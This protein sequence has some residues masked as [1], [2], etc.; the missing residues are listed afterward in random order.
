MKK[1]VLILMMAGVLVSCSQDDPWSD[2]ENISGSQENSMNGGFVEGGSGKGATLTNELGTFD[3]KLDA[4]PLVESE[5]IPDESD[6]YYEDYVECFTPKS[7]IGVVF[8]E[9]TATVNGSA[10][11][12]TI[13][14]DGAHVTVN[15]TVKNVAYILS[16]ST[17]NGSF[18]IYSEKKF[19]LTLNGVS[20]TNPNGAAINNQGKRAYVVVNDGTE[21]MLADGSSYTMVE[22][23]DQKGTL[24]SEGKLAFSGKG[25]LAVYANG[26]SGIVSDDYVL[27]RPN[28]NIYVKSVSNHGIKSNDGIIIKGGVVNVEVS[29]A[30]SKGLNTDGFIQIDGGRTSVITTGETEYDDE[31]KE[32]KGCAA[33][34]ADSII[35]MNGGKLNVKSIGGGGKGISSD[36]TF[37]MNGGS[38][39]AIAQGSNSNDVSAKAIKI[40]GDIVIAGG[41][42]MARA[43]SHEAIESKGKMTITAGTVAAYSSDDAINSA[44][45]MHI[46]GGY[47]YAYSTGNDAIDANGNLTISGGVVIA[48][49]A[50]S[51]EE[52]IDAAEGKTLSF[53]G[54]TII[55]IGG[56][57]E[58]TSGSQ[59]KATIRGISISSG[60]YLTVHDSN[61]NNIFAFKT[62]RAYSNA[63]LQVSSP[64]FSSG[65]TYTLGTASS[66]SGNDSFYGFISSATVSG[67]T[68][69]GTFTT[70]TTTSGGMGGGFPG[71]NGG[72][73]G[74]PGRW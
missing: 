47:V 39:M 15:S 38:I 13:T 55:G 41:S 4:T 42:I 44:S 60:S 25:K 23:E 37:T 52:G 35:V 24:F 11:G 20:I 65:T 27:I 30:S 62:P 40:D 49:G 63:T 10:D 32:Y 59:Q 26:K 16:G 18:K 50:L 72:G 66:A 54:G 51:P 1:I 29:A 73:G 2:Y 19:Q 36:Q 34:K 43:A 9:G 7:L 45:D 28:T 68:N 21:N 69:L 71:G 5:T 22:N 48:C 31:D 46:S 53:N 6:I 12:V 8:S 67:E 56:G 64:N 3:V 58:A 14:I 33:L 70:S 57:A 74:F 61:G 17:S